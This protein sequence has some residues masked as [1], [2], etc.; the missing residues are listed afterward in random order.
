[1]VPTRHN[2]RYRKKST[3]QMHIEIGGYLHVCS[4]QLPIVENSLILKKI[5]TLVHTNK[6]NNK[7]P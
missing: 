6:S 1:M 2:V 4:F 5:R 7:C 3:K